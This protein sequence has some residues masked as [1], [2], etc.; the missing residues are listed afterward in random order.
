MAQYLDN[1]GLNELVKK[2]KEYARKS[3]KE[4]VVKAGPGETSGYGVDRTITGWNEVSSAAIYSPI[5]IAESQVTGLVDDLALKAPLASP[6]FTGVPTAPLADGTNVSAVANVK[7]VLDTVGNIGEAMHYKGAVDGT[8]HVLPS[9][10]F[11]AG[12]TYKVSVAGEYAGKNCEVGDMIIANTSAAAGA[13][14]NDKW[15]VIQTNIDGA[16]TG[17]AASTDGNF[18]VFDGE[19]GKVIKNSTVNPSS[20]KTKQTDVDLSGSTI[21]TITSLTQNA[22][23]EV[24]ATFQNIQTASTSQI[25]LVQLSSSSASTAEDVAA[26]PKAVKDAYDVLNAA[27][28]DNLTFDGTYDPSTN[29]AATVATVS[30]AIQTLDAE[31]DSTGGTNVSVKVNEV[32]GKI[33]AVTITDNTVN[34]TDV[35]NAITT[36]IEGLDVT[37]SAIPTSGTITSISETDGKIAITSAAIAITTDQ[38]T[39]FSTVLDGKADKKVP[40]AV[41]NIAILDSEGNLDDAGYG[42]DHF[43]TVQTAV[44]DPSAD[45]TGITFI[46]SASQDTNGVIT[47][48][49]KTVQSADGTQPGLMSASDFTK[50]SQISTS[51]NRVEVDQSTG[52]LSIDGTSA[53][54]PISTAEIDGLF[55]EA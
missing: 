52:V 36:A 34:A 8:T 15:D 37:A 29:K 31:V 43:K 10:D 6:E 7:Y 47:L 32:D 5:Q 22:N 27:K 51:A 41:G 42:I 20:F 3:A 17:P 33:T 4:A 40:A 50:L 1:N 12:D 44:A 14:S 46:D 39:D 38:I 26:T 49:K 45:G 13:G 54:G 48:H 28:Q 30:G 9:G 11:K 19:T 53:M 21:K 18:V 2:T 23:G 55:N 25:G 16:V 24:S 35:S